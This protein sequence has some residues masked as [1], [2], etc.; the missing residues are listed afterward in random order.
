MYHVSNCF[1]ILLNE[2]VG[3][4]LFA[5]IFECMHF[6]WHFFLSTL[7][8]KQRQNN[9]QKGKK[10]AFGWLSERKK[11]DNNAKAPNRVQVHKKERQ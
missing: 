5:L 4:S 7:W 2:L 10:I 3:E 11:T 1:S 6:F 8:L 9:K